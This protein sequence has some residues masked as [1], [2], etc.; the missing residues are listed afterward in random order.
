MKYKT[1][2]IEQKQSKKLWRL[3]KLSSGRTDRIKRGS[4]N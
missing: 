1:G 2:K 3:I 4:T